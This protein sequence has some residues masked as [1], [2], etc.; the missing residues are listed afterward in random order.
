[1]D[2]N[3]VIQLKFRDQAS[4]ES[5]DRPIEPH[6]YILPRECAL[7]NELSYGF[8]QFGGIAA[9]LIE[10][11]RVGNSEGVGQF[12]GAVWTLTFIE[13]IADAN[14]FLSGIAPAQS[15]SPRF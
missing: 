4:Q 12:A 5:V 9:T 3:D 11:T 14:D 1:M 6:S 13:A 15:L 2:L 7:G 10:L 8:E